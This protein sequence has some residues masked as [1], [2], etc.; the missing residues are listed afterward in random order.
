M[1]IEKTSGVQTLVVQFIQRVLLSSINDVWRIVVLRIKNVGKT[2]FQGS[3]SRINQF[4]ISQPPLRFIWD[5]W[6]ILILKID[7]HFI[8]PSKK[9]NFKYV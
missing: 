8:M 1:L 6:G 4:R 2:T 9:L 7:T 5:M 3:D